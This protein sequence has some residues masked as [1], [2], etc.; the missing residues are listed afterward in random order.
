MEPSTMVRGSEIASLQ[1]NERHVAHNSERLFL[2]DLLCFVLSS[3]CRYPSLSV[4]ESHL[5]NNVVLQ[6]LLQLHR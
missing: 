4:S 6:L 2:A 5:L 3:R 1:L